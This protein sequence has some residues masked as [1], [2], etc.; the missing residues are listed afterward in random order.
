MKGA[1]LKVKLLD[2]SIHYESIKDEVLRAIAGVCDGQ[3]FILG[4]NVSLLEDEIAQYCGVEYAVGVAS[5]SDA[6]MLALMALG[7]G[8]GDKVATTPYTFFS[9]AGSVA[10]LGATPVFVDIDRKTY[11]LSP[12]RLEGVLRKTRG[13]KAVIPVH[14]YG[15]SADMTQINGVAKKYGVK[16]VEDAAQSIG[17]LHRGK[18]AGSMGDV[19]CFSFYPSKNLGA[20]GDAGMVATGKKKLADTL[21]MLRVHGS[22]RRYYHDILGV[23]SRLD[24]LQAAVLRVK[25][26][27]LDKWT[28]KRREN[29]AL[30]DGL[31]EKEGLLAPPY[32]EKDNFSAFNQYVV[33]V[34]R[35]DGL[36]EFLSSKGIG[37]EVYYPVPLH[38]QKCFKRLGYKK[39]DFPESELAAGETLALPIYPELK[40]EEIEY[41]VAAIK[42]FYL[43]SFWGKRK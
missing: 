7:V 12:E 41:V 28:E 36:R 2:L 22:N 43:L 24:E 38:L 23:N 11:N 26:R 19:G 13:V 17:A 25:L 37:T 40:R 10:L 21:K 16:V 29:A 31:F 39:G 4:E 34:K 1:A 27:Y 14:L 30:Y 33:R 20:F 8:R 42:E 15:Q 9:T 3:R 35:R 18:K 6:I 32:V 5:G